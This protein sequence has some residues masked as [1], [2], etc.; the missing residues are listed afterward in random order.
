[1][2]VGSIDGLDEH[3]LNELVARGSLDFDA[4]TTLISSVE[5]MYHDDIDKISLVY[6]SFLSEFPLCHG[7][8]KKY[9]E[10]T[11]HLCSAERVVRIFERAVEAVPYSVGVW[12]DYC[13]F[14][15][16]SFEDPLDVCR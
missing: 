4:W 12:V 1:M 16:S 13:S 9:A 15:I 2:A 5:Q 11:T 7:Y 3:L 8:R 6:D 14:D 10:H